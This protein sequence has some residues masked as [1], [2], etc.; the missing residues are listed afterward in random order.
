MICAYN[1]A[2]NLTSNSFTRP[3]YTFNRLEHR[4]GTAY[5]DGQEIINLKGTQDASL[6]LYAQWER[7]KV[8]SASK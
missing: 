8:T 6:T 4:S 7:V 3:N 5:T 2:K 1:V